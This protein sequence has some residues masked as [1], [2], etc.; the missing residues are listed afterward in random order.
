[1]STLACRPLSHSNY[2][3]VTA[4]PPNVNGPPRQAWVLKIL[5][6]KLEIANNTTSPHEL[7]ANAAIRQN[8][9]IPDLIGERIW[10]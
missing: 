3:P 1:M 6:P 8:V 5:I 4:S 2:V 7:Q 9:L 10:V